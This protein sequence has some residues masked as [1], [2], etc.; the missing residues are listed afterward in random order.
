MKRLVLAP[1]I[2]G[3]L[4]EIYRYTAAKFGVAQAERYELALRNVFKLIQD[5][6]A[7]GRLRDDIAPG[8]RSFSVGSHVVFY[9]V[10][11]VIEIVG[12]PHGRSDLRS[13]FSKNRSERAKHDDR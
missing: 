11:D 2:P 5:Y 13:Y 3:E 1:R 12:V 10:T 7:A 8:C 6:E 9:F 4:D